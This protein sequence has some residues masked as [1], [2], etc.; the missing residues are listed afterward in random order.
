M[1]KRDEHGAAPVASDSKTESQYLIFGLHSLSSILKA[2]YH[3]MPG[4]WVGV[5]LSNLQIKKSQR[6]SDLPKRLAS[7]G[8]YVRTQIFSMLTFSGRSSA[9]IGLLD[10]CVE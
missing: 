4:S 3:F 5:V 10:P 6:H 9:L 8:A 7:N 1:I 2:A